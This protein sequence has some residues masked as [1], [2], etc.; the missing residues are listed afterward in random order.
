MTSQTF[1]VRPKD[2]KHTADDLIEVEYDTDLVGPD[3]V[4]ILTP[5][6][7][8]STVPTGAVPTV[9]SVKNGL[10]HIAETNMSDTYFLNILIVKRSNQ[11]EGYSDI[12]D[13]DRIIAETV[14]KPHPGGQVLDGSTAGAV[15][16]LTAYQQGATTPVTGVETNANPHNNEAVSRNGGPDYFINHIQS[17]SHPNFKE[18]QGDTFGR[19]T[20]QTQRITFKTPWPTPPTLFITPRSVGYPQ[21]QGMAASIETITRVSTHDFEITSTNGALPGRDKSKAFYVDWLAL[22][23]APQYHKKH[24]DQAVA[25]LKTD[26]PN[27]AE[28]FTKH[29]AEAE[30]I[31][32]NGAE[33]SQTLQ[34]IRAAPPPE[35]KF[36]DR[37]QIAPL[38]L[39]IGAVVVDGIGLL[40]SCLGV[41]ASLNVTVKNR[42]I[43]NA[44][45]AI[46]AQSDEERAL[47]VNET[48]A[49]TQSVQK[50][51]TAADRA[52][53]QARIVAF[54]SGTM[55]KYGV[56]KTLLGAYFSS[57]SWWQ[58]FIACIKVV[59]QFI[60]V[61]A[62]LIG[63]AG[64]LTAVQVATWIA[65]I[66]ALILSATQLGLD[67]QRLI[68][69]LNAKTSAAPG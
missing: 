8:G 46:A 44:A 17:T 41:V 29:Q 66:A 49:L 55:W 1:F 21:G 20:A 45:A 5:Q 67:I 13:M 48:T 15:H 69:D 61:V 37:D 40:L 31:I 27:Q 23:A 35:P 11:Q 2:V 9:A 26:F 63:T 59:A 53:N 54:F 19:S 60:T 39:D 43:R 7:N 56:V 16:M 38:W 4:V 30:Q 28:H 6:W 65:R 25:R 68:H 42:A 47:F 57:M 64:A 10:I 50:A 32:L 58:W 51:K 34:H 62:G 24:V 36:A 22:S 12:R 18:V 3:P 52:A 33:P 14:P